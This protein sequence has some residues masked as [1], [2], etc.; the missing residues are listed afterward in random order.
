MTRQQR[1]AEQRARTKQSP[2]RNVVTPTQAAQRRAEREAAELENATKRL[3]DAGYDVT[4]GL[5]QREAP[6]THR[7]QM[8]VALA[9]LAGGPSIVI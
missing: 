9:S 4:V 2:W 7:A 5:P 8:A 1:R 3:T 6:R